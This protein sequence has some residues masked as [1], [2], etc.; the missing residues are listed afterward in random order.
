MNIDS[1]MGD[2]HVFLLYCVFVT[3]RGLVGSFNC[4]HVVSDLVNRGNGDKS[5]RDLNLGHVVEPCQES[6]CI[7][8]NINSM[9]KC[10]SLALLFS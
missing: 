1:K 9:M 4:Y 8:S 6:F 2:M 3:N 5:Q 7:Q 10:S